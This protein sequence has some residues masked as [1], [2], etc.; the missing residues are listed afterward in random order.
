MKNTTLILGCGDIGTTLGRE[1]L[2]AG[3]RVVGVRRHP[4]KLA[5]TGIEGRAAD[6]GDAAALAEL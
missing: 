5:G 2:A 3:H 1:L 6:L 4:D